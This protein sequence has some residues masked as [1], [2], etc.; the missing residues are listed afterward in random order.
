M[1]RSNGARW[2][3]DRLA[4]LLPEKGLLTL[5]CGCALDGSLPGCQARCQAMSHSENGQ[6][7]DVMEESEEDRLIKGYSGKVTGIIIPPPEIR[8]IADKTSQ[9]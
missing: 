8:A 9:W 6:N 7:G 5:R 4:C 2:C 1:G 3:S